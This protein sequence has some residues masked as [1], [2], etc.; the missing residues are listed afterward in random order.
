MYSKEGASTELVT[1]INSLYEKTVFFEKLPIETQKTVINILSVPSYSNERIYTFS[2]VSGYTVALHYDGTGIP[3]G[4]TPT[5][6]TLVEAAFR[7][8]YTNLI[9][10]FSFNRPITSGSKFDIYL[11][12]S[13][14]DYTQPLTGNVSYI[15]LEIPNLNATALT[16]YQQ[17]S[18]AHEL[19]HA[20][21]H[22]YRNSGDLPKWFKEAWAEWAA[23]ITF[24]TYPSAKAG[25]V[26]QYLNTTWQS[27]YTAGTSPNQNRE[28][29]TVLFPLF[30][31]QNNSNNIVAQTVK[32]LSSTSDVYYA[33]STAAG[34]SSTETFDNLFPMFAQ[35]NYKP[36]L[37]YNHAQSGWNDSPYLSANYALNSYPNNEGIWL[38][39]SVSAHYRDFA[40]PASGQPNFRID[41]TINVT[42]GQ[43]SRLRCRLMMT[44][45]T[46]GN[47][48]N[49]VINQSGTT[50]LI[51][52]SKS[53]LSPT[54]YGK[55]C[56]MLSNNDKLGN[57]INYRITIARS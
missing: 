20:I 36:K 2:P 47:T 55:G 5:A 33:I 30:L 22:K 12:S 44:K 4:K 35:A 24:S 50:S 18:V 53:G 54:T 15:H 46:G 10:G 3:V 42:N 27:L 45:R 52:I 11:E 51:T 21:I 40:V 32:N 48:D 13:G 31:R 1:Q 25:Q 49:W 19:T 7:T 8:S 41:V 23:Y 14:G 57:G 38:V 26:S 28:Y 37:F 6:V 9:T 29:G 39:N 43:T 16:A 34:G 17:G 56:I